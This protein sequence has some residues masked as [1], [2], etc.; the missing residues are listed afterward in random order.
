MVVDLANEFDPMSRTEV[1]YM[2]SLVNL[3]RSTYGQRPIPLDDGE[4][5]SSPTLTRD[6]SSAS[7]NVW[8]VPKLAWHHVGA[9]VLLLM[10]L[11]DDELQL[12]TAH[13]PDGEFEKLLFCRLSVHGGAC[14]AERMC[15]IRDGVFNG[16]RGWTGK[17][18]QATINPKCL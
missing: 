5:E 18:V 8:P 6:L 13:V 14:Y 9:R 2:M 15:L 10:R 1:S 16:R 17:E 12:R 11:D 7:R 3:A 4:R